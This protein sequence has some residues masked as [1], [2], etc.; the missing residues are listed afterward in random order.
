MP[1]PG[2]YD[3]ADQPKYRDLAAAGLPAAAPLIVRETPFHTLRLFGG[4]AAGDRP[5]V[6]LVPPLS[7]HF[8]MLLHDMVAG[9]PPWC[10][11]AVLDW[12]NV[13]HVA[14]EHGPFGFEDNCAAISG[15]ME[16]LPPPLSVV[17]LCQGGV[18]ALTAV[19]DLARH[20]PERAPDSLVLIAAPVDPLAN[21]T[22]VVRL[23]RSLTVYWYATVP[24]QR[25][26]RGYEGRGRWVYPARTQ[27]AG[28]DSYLGHHLAIDGDELP[29]R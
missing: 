12:A 18:P 19:A 26:G 6:L 10:R 29:A 16:T 15:A 17:A 13:R 27:L 22:P 11:V 9:L 5:L 23:I 7:G 1:G 2:R 25:V 20:R 14:A 28:L 24:I 4:H 21:P 3:G 8:P